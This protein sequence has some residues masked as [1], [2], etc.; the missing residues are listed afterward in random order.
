[1]ENEQISAAITASAVESDGKTKLSCAKAFEIAK[2]FAISKQTVGK[3][4]NEND[5][6]IAACQLGCFK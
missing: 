5:I 4:C 2:Q 3:L 1:M 6:K